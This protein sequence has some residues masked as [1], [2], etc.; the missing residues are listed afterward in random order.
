V[1]SSQKRWTEHRLYSRRGHLPKGPLALQQRT[2]FPIVL[3]ARFCVSWTLQQMSKLQCG[4]QGSQCIQD[5]VPSFELPRRS[6]YTCTK[7]AVCPRWAVD[8]LCLAGEQIHWG[9]S[10]VEVQ[11]PLS[12]STPHQY[13]LPTSSRHQNSP[14]GKDCLVASSTTCLRMA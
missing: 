13:S 11:C 12:M 14:K 10:I 5:P 8:E 4:C 7:E 6:A 2:A 9:V 3:Y 1:Q